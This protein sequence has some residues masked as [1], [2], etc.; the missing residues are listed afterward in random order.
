MGL[1]SVRAKLT[2][3][4]GKSEELD[5]LVDTGSFHM[6]LPKALAER[7][8]VIPKHKL[9]VQLAGGQIGYWPI[10]YVELALEGRELAVP[11]LVAPGG[12]CILGALALEFLTLGVDPKNKRLIPIVLEQRP[13]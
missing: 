2:G 7:L 11:T 8:E 5:L 12:Q 10:A 9:P 4:Q 1:F 3:P 6:I 13:L